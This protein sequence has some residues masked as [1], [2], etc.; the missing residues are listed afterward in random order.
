[1]RWVGDD[2]A[3]ADRGGV[4]SPPFPELTLRDGDP[5]D[6]PLFPQVWPRA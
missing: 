1:A 3:F 4:T 6:S 5:L 2:A